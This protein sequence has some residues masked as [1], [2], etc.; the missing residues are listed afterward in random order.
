MIASIALAIA[1]AL[2]DDGQRANSDGIQLA[3]DTVVSMENGPTVLKCRLVNESG[4]RQDVLLKND[5]MPFGL[6]YAFTKNA[7]PNPTPSSLRPFSFKRSGGLEGPVRIDAGES[8]PVRYLYLHDAWVFRAGQQY[9]L[10]LTWTFGL[11]GPDDQIRSRAA[12]VRVAIKPQADDPTNRAELLKRLSKMIAAPRVDLEDYTHCSLLIAGCR[13]ETFRPLAREL[14]IRQPTSARNVPSVFNAEDYRAE[15]ATEVIVAAIYNCS[16]SREEAFEF[17]YGLLANHTMGSVAPF[18][19]FWDRQERRRLDCVDA[20]LQVFGLTAVPESGAYSSPR[21]HTGTRVSIRHPDM[22]LRPDERKRLRACPDAAVQALLLLRDPKTSDS[23]AVARV[24]RGLLT[25]VE[26]VKQDV[27]DRL[28]ADLK[29]S[30]FRTREAAEK[31]LTDYGFRVLSQLA[32]SSRV[33][34]DPEARGRQERLMAALGKKQ[35][36]P[37]F[38]ELVKAASASDKLLGEPVLRVLADSQLPEPFRKY[39]RETLSSL[40]G[41]KSKPK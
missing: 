30:S 6:S 15:L 34:A 16:S 3:V 20:A 5:K 40:E 26:P 1:L 37:V 28:I 38:F 35:V 12:R 8:T 31:E 39:A 29:S 19:D 11:V 13:H 9:E 14:L 33:E 41:Q 23:E 4:G 36:P 7:A 18:L 22:C 24:Q 10:N 27:F 25:L 21:E 32:K 2:A 17:I